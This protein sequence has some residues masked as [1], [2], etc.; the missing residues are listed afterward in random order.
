[1]SIGRKVK[2]VVSGKPSYERWTIYQW[3]MECK[4]I[5]EREYSIRVEV[6]VCDSDESY[7]FIIVNDKV[8]VYPPFEEGY[9]I[10]YLKKAIERIM[11]D[12]E[13]EHN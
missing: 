10:E 1:M 6:L 4:D 11:G 7:P 3:L 8:V 13:K 9:L 2:I 5:V 12:L